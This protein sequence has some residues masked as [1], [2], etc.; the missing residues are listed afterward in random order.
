MME[1]NKAASAIKTAISLFAL[2]AF[3]GIAFL[4]FYE[5]GIL[6][7]GEDRVLINSNDDTEK[8][9]SAYFAGR[10]APMG[11]S[12]GIISAGRF[13]V[14]KASG[15]TITEESGLLTDPIVRSKGNFAVVANY[16][17]REAQLYEKGAAAVGVETEGTIVS[18]ATNSNGFFAVASEQMGYETV[19]NV[20]KKNGEAI[21]RYI[22]SGKSF[23]DMDISENNR[24]LVI[25][26]ANLDLGAG[27]SVT[28]ANF[29][30]SEAEMTI[31]VSDQIYFAVHFNKNGSFIC[32]G[33]MRVDL[34]RQNGEKYG[35]IDYSGRALTAS[36]ISEDDMICLAFSGSVGE[37]AKAEVYNR[38]G[39]LRGEA[40][41][42][43]TVTYICVNGAYIAASHGSEIDIMTRNGKTKT[44]L[45][46]SGK[47]KYAAPFSDGKSAV[48]F[49][50]GST[51]ILK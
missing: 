19:I 17:G 39:K 11:E 46:A 38:D 26:T 30:Q 10:P 37:G 1:R 5:A 18:V 14:V 51:E 8:N 42:N 43:E 13:T 23:I 41:F 31:D 48:V 21:Y 25:L 49:S 2:A 29:N 33:D 28:L 44:K 16:G 45:T 15:S 27:S 50:E 4:Q 6:G 24:K 32:Q 9:L 20:Y 40:E 34:Y 36:D 7:D 22:L 47:V 12:I 3:I 35:A